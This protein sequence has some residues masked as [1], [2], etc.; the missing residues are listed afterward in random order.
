MSPDSW[1][2]FVRTFSMRNHGNLI[3]KGQYVNL[4]DS[5]TIPRNSSPGVQQSAHLL[6]SSLKEWIEMA[7][8]CASCTSRGKAKGKH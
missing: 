2:L 4:S 7:S 5:R 1:T 3:P 8:R 6:S